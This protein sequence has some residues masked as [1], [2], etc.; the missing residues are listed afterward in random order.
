MRI[1]T[2]LALSFALAATVGCNKKKQEGGDTPNPGSGSA[3]AGSGSGSAGSGAGSGA[4]VATVSGAELAKVVIDCVAAVSGGDMA[5][6]KGCLADDFSSHDAGSNKDTARDQVLAMFGEMRKGFPDMAFAPQLVLVNGRRVAVVELETGTNSG[7]LKTAGGELP[8]TNKKLGSL[9]FH[10]LE[11]DASNRASSEW[12]IDDTGTT[13]VQLGVGP[14]GVSGRPLMDQP[15]AGAPMVVVASDDPKEQANIATFKAGTDAFNAHDAAGFAA[16]LAP[17]VVESDQ[18]EAA[19]T[20]GAKQVQ[21]STAQFIQAFSDGQLEDRELWA[22]GDFVV[23]IGSFTGTFDHDI[24]PVKKTGKIVTI[25][26]AEIAQFKDG[27]IATL[28]RFR[29][30][31]DMAVQMGLL[32][33]PPGADGGSGSAGSGSA[34]P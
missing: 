1:S 20:V 28:W 7:T 6:F 32:K 10:R 27:K 26:Y 5:T 29:N 2:T 24:G 12:F 11:L 30:G 16:T 14:K 19:D 4:A 9:F 3:L 17:G 33:P 22:A 21:A 8:A 34:A 25:P 23:A 15:M 31:V 13:L 18:A